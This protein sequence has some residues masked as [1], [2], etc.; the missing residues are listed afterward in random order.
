MDKK[1]IQSDIGSVYCECKN[2]GT[3]EY[4]QIRAISDE[5]PN[6][7]LCMLINNILPIYNKP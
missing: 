7:S 6:C 3:P 4:F 1:T 5:M 2:K